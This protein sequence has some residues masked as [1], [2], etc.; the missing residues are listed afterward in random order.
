MQ[1]R[2]RVSSCL[3]LGAPA[4]L[5]ALLV[6]TTLV[7]PGSPG[8][9]SLVPPP[10]APV[11]TALAR[12]IV[13]R[14]I[15][16]P[17]AADRGEAAPPSLP[18]PVAPPVALGVGASLRIN[19]EPPDLAAAV[20]SRSVAT[21]DDRFAR[22]EQLRADG[23]V[24]SAVALLDQIRSTADRP[25]AAQATFQIARAYLLD[26]DATS[27]T[28]ALRAYLQS[29]PDQ[30]D[31]PGARLALAIALTAAGQ[32][33]AAE[34]LYQQYLAQTTDHTLDGYA[35][36]ALARGLDQR[37]DLAAVDD[38]RRAIAA[39]LPASDELDAATRVAA[40]F[41]RAGDV[42]GAVDWYVGLA[43]R[44]PATDP[45]RADY[46]VRAADCAA[47][48]GQRDRA[49]ALVGDLIASGAVSG[50][51]VDELVNLRTLGVSI[52]DLAL[53]TASLAAGNAAAAVSAFGD[54]LDRY[55]DGANVA[56]AR[57]GRGQALLEAG[58]YSSAAAQLQKFLDTSPG[59]SRAAA[60]KALLAR[61]QAGLN[62][63]DGGAA[64]SAATG[65]P[66]AAFAQ[67]WTAYE[68]LDLATA[69]ATWSGVL[70]R[71]PNDPTSPPALLWLAK[72]DLKAGNTA[73]ALHEL[74]QAW[75]ANPGDYYAFRARELATTLGGASDLYPPPSSDPSVERAR[76]ENWLAL[77]THAPSDASQHAYLDAAI[78]HTA[79][80]ERMRALE[81]LGLRDQVDGEYRAA[82]DL[83]WSDGRSL[84][85]L[86]DTLAQLGLDPQSMKVAYHL[87][88]MSPAPNA[89]Q[90]PTYLQRL[91]YPFPYR[92]LVEA[93]ARKY[94]VDPLLLVALMR[95][96]SSFDPRAGSSA[97][98]RGLT[99]FMPSTAAILAPSVGLNHFVP[100]DLDRPS[101]AIPMGAAY[102]ADLTRE[103]GGKPYL[104]LAAYNAGSGNVRSWLG[105]N[106][107]DD[108]DLLA[109]EIPFQE[110]RGYVRN[111][112]RFY[113][114]Y[115]FLYGGPIGNE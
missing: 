42:G 64:A 65:G 74:R 80:L 89:Y 24:A 11:A 25:T 1:R 113:Q 49:T 5:G 31:A 60:A 72:L 84:Y 54:Y 88:M 87:L 91:V 2:S 36:L 4:V 86:A 16:P 81:S 59:D 57:F 68:A 105:D 94:G 46:L 58:D 40:G 28:S 32:S 67:G 53:G 34:P 13:P 55:P 10:P 77:W 39:G 45:L 17:M 83:Y 79:A 99:Q 29:Y 90:A 44:Y 93:A 115:R 104:A 3:A 26:G 51:A 41:I 50:K 30:S 85:A 7:A 56:T 92:D 27:G 33:A 66:Q 38:Y 61:A 69:R 22:A 19:P 110:T 20:A 43:D 12:P 18:A 23:E 35:W 14:P 103:F 76:F 15:A 75:N 78:T 82:I 101:V 112:Y 9:G 98:A 100:D 96:E 37:G 107:H 52:D 114:E 95:Q 111:V 70:Q 47:R 109:E 71:A 97:G 102:L 106:P 73:S 63:Q 62:S 21:S 48:N 6:G 8:L 108:F